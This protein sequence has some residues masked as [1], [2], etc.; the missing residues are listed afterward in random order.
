VSGVDIGEVQQPRDRYRRFAD[1][2]VAGGGC[3]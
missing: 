3:E 1:W 2:F